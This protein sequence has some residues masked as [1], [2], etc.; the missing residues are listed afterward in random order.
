MSRSIVY[1]GTSNR[2][3]AGAKRGVGKMLRGVSW[4]RRGE[5]LRRRSWRGEGEALEFGGRGKEQVSVASPVLSIADRQ[6]Q[7]LGWQ[8]EDWQAGPY[9]H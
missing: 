1:D 9:G 8:C 3:K 4:R 6:W 7:P 2:L 5:V